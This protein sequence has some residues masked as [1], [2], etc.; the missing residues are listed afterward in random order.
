MAQNC[1][2]SSKRYYLLH[3]ELFT[4]L[5]VSIAGC[6]GDDFDVYTDNANLYPP[7]SCFDPSVHGLDAIYASYPNATILLTV[8]NTD[9]WIQSLQA[10]LFPNNNGDL[11]S[12]LQRCKNLWPTQL[13]QRQHQEEHQQQELMVGPNTNNSTTMNESNRTHQQEQ[14]QQLLTTRDI[15]NFYEWHTQHVRDFAAA[16]PSLT[17]IEVKLEDETTASVLQERVGI[18]ASCGGRHNQRKSPPL[19]PPPP[20]NLA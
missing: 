3:I 16:H 11:L 1:T 17:Y 20:S 10:F 6:G 7:H 14:Q 4:V 18:S 12:Y 13:I 15:R 9:D 5:Y 2:L 19:P 8:R